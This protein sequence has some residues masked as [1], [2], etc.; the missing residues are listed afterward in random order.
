[1]GWAGFLSSDHTIYHPLFLT[2]LLHLFAPSSSINLMSCE[3]EDY[4]RSR[5][6]YDFLRY[7]EKQN[8]IK[9]YCPLLCVM[10]FLSLEGWQWERL[11]KEWRE[12]EKKGTEEII[13]VDKSQTLL[14]LD[15]L[16]NVAAGTN[17][18][19]TQ[20]NNGGAEKQKW[21]GKRQMEIIM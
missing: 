18:C 13:Y 5:L 20:R 21:A 12:S 6:E 14:T 10:L 15:F 9:H 1:M 17:A 7:W 2:F 11:S 4:S 8:K 19:V 16:W 3:G